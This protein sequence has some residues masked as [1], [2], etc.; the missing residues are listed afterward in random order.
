MN[1]LVGLYSP[2]KG[3]TSTHGGSFAD[4]SEDNA[5]ETML[6]NSNIFYDKI[7]EDYSLQE[8]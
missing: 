6:V 4:F 7:K 5:V 8:Q 3:F 2:T 1:P